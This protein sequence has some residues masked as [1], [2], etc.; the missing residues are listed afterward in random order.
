[1]LIDSG[2]SDCS[3]VIKRGVPR[4]PLNLTWS[5]RVLVIMMFLFV[6]LGTV[7]LD[8]PTKP[9]DHQIGKSLEEGFGPKL[10]LTI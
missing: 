1:M 8:L 10:K 9:S 7:V 2:A 5:T 4:I 3:P 6:V